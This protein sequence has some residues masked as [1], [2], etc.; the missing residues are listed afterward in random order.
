MP[1]EVFTWEYVEKEARQLL[2]N[3]GYNEIRTPIFEK[4]ELFVRSVGQT[5]D[6]V[7]K[8]ML[9]LSFQGFVEKY[10]FDEIGLD[11]G[12]VF[13]KLI[14]N[15][16]AEKIS[17][18]QIR[19]KSYLFEGKVI[20]EMKKVFE[21][22]EV[23]DKILFP[24]YYTSLSL[25]PEGTA[26]IVRAYIQNNFDR[27]ERLSKFFYIGP[28]FRGERPQKGRLRQFH[29]IGAEAIGPESCSPYLDAEIIAL[30]VAILKALGLSDFNLKL[31]SLGDEED[32]ENFSKYL[33]KELKPVSGN[34]CSNCQRRYRLNVLRVL[35]CN[36]KDCQAIVDGLDI[37]DAHL[38]DKSREYFKEV[39][40]ALDRLKV[41]YE[42]F[43][44][45]VRGLDYYTHTVFEIS[46]PSLGSQDA[47]GA[48][49]RYSNLVS[50]LGGP[51]V[52]AVGFALGIERIL[53]AMPKGDVEAGKLNVFIIALDEKSFLKA[54]ALLH[55]LRDADVSGDMSYRISSMKSQMRLA[56]KKGAGHVI[57]LGEAEMQ[58]GEVTI[59]NMESGDQEVE[60]INNIKAI[61]NM[62][63][64]Q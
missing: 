12:D 14:E 40:G 38:S 2:R 15:G 17:P 56:D 45:L 31:N 8:Q 46:A 6:I 50:Q 32:K 54:F 51:D 10:Q 52:D 30:S 22:D 19:L 25:R 24:Q 48:G 1:K 58:K 49:G 16:W 5:S 7:Q 11:S 53:L 28:M 64:N 62:I 20:G 42:I 47:L 34:F 39:C 33:K 36:N 44:K 23:L 60:S 57:I 3:Y 41:S 37:H 27:L 26:S 9:N 35:D 21:D 18:T 4:S 63:L 61:K 13:K 43:P 55:Q 29:Q 59:K